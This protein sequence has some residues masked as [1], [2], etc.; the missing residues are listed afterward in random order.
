LRRSRVEPP[1]GS[2]QATRVKGLAHSRT[3]FDTWNR[4]FDATLELNY[5]AEKTG[6]DGQMPRW[7]KYPGRAVTQGIDW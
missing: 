7:L 6:V 3:G 1:G 2:A 5:M 4:V